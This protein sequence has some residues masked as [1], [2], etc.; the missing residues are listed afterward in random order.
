[1]LVAEQ[2]EQKRLR[3]MLSCLIVPIVA[4]CNSMPPTDIPH[5]MSVRPIERPVTSRPTNGSIF[6]SQATMGSLFEDARPRHAGDIITVQIS[7]NINA[8]RNL[9]TTAERQTSQETSV[10]ALSPLAKAAS[11]IG[12]GS[13]LSPTVTSSSSNSLKGKGNVNASDVFTGTIT[14]TV[15]DVYPNGNLLISGEKLM[16]L[17]GNRE[18]LRL[19][20]VVNPSTISATNTVLSTQIA[21]A[22]I[23]YKGTGT[24]QEMQELGW[25]QKFFLSVLPF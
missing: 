25:L 23:E 6:H 1:M 7:E 3:C 22:R 5:P 24:L 17:G 8:T 19:S 15:V 9:N 4:G 20:G 12:A 13:L 14:V 10:T 21:D 11:L 18:F 2:N 16:S